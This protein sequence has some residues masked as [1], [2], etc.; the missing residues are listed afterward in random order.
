MAKRAQLAAF[1]LVELLVVIVIAGVLASIAG[2]RFFATN[3][4]DE[5]GYADELG[6]ALRYGQKVAVATGCPV[7]V[8]VTAAGYA[9][10][11]QTAAA[12]HCN[13][14]DASFATPVLLPD[15]QAVAG[16]AP[17]GVV[18][19][20]AVSFRFLPTGDTSLGADTTLAVGARAVTVSAGSGLVVSQ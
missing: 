13:P 12:G 14:A 19:A 8:T 20:P 6:A 4:F 9:L 2:P 15:G 17:A 18:A 3:A 16:N 11:Q 10:G 5:R 1:T 7:Q